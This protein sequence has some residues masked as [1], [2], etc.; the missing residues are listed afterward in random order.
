MGFAAAQVA[1]AAG[2]SIVGPV[3]HDTNVVVLAATSEG[4]L[5]TVAEA[6]ADA[7]TPHV[8][9]REPDPPWLGAA[10]A[11]GLP[12]MPRQAAPRFLKRLA[13]YG[14]GPPP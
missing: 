13:L 12:P 10:T 1:H 5:I 9:V 4:H 2:E 6:L 3:P 8:L 7:G 14:G 11:I